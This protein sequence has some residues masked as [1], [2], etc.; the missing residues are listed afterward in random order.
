MG[1][2]LGAFI[3]PLIAGWLALKFG[4]RVGFL[5]AAIGMPLGLL[6]FWLSRNLLGSAGASPH[7]PDG[8]SGPAA[9]LD[10]AGRGGRD[11]RVR[12]FLLMSGIVAV[13]PAPLA[14]ARR[15]RPGRHGGR[16]IFS[17]CSSAPGS[18]RSSASASSSCW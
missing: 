15:L 10:G 18:T 1:I 12:G 16:R 2:N 6:Q 5:A 7:R 9:R 13:N 14:K 8:G 17:T 4:W 3:G 11:A